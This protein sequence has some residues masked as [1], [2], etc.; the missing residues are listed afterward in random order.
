MRSDRAAPEQLVEEI[1][2][3]AVAKNP[4]VR[5]R[6]QGHAGALDEQLFPERGDHRPA[7]QAALAG[8]IVFQMD[9]TTFA[10]KSVLW[11][12]GKR[13]ALAD[14]ERHLRLLV[15]GDIKK[16]EWN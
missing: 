1:L 15:G 14:L 16:A 3:S 10:A 13:G 12:V 6:T 11:P 5:C 9:Q 7:L 4:V 2:S 8:G